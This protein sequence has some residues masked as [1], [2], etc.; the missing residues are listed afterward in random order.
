MYNTLRR[1]FYLIGLTNSPYVGGVE[2]RKKSQPTFVRV[3]SCGF[4]QTYISGLLPSW[5]H[6]MLKS[7]SLGEIWNRAPMTWHQIVGHKG[8]I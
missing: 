2:Q 3:C 7:L 1:H 6:R 8:P 5:T 4:T